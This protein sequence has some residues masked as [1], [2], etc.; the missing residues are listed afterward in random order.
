[1]I[2]APEAVKEPQK[3]LKENPAAPK[4]SV[5]IPAYNVAEY[6][7]ETLG[8]ALAQTFESREII[9]VNDGSPD[10]AEFEKVISPYL[11]KIIYLT[12][13]NKGAAAARNAGI[14]IAKGEILAFLDGDDIWSAEYLERQVTFM[15]SSGAEMV[16]CDAQLFGDVKT[17]ETFMERS[18]SNGR[19]TT[20][21]LLSTECNVITSGTMVRRE[22]VVEA[23][24]FDENAAPRVEDFELWI[25]LLKNGI[26][27]D[28]QKTVLL[29]YRVRLGGLTGNT[30]ERAE[31]SVIALNEV[32]RKNTFTA[33]E[34]AAWNRHFDRAEKDFNAQKGKALL[35]EKR[36]DEALECFE[37]SNRKIKSLKAAVII[38]LVRFT[39]WLA[40]M[41]FK[42]FRA[43][44]AEAFAA[45]K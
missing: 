38:N 31:R 10:T 44:E 21:S 30:L 3:T 24:M 22:K 4:V 18:P 6:I 1:M 11:E 34:Q 14:K 35:I 45:K 9:V 28:Y 17:T 37:A 2:S 27:A 41:I 19:V 26:K 42:K 7:F 39:P 12:Q 40:T 23:G 36:Y 25:R 15:T 13:P 29:K 33:E 8:S 5:I 43:D 32:K 20:E 16:Y